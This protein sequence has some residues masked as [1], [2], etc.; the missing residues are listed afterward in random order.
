ME[1]NTM[2][3]GHRTKTWGMYDLWMV[4]ST[5]WFSKIVNWN[6][7][8][9]WAIAICTTFIS[10]ILGIGF[11]IDPGVPDI[12]GY[13]IFAVNAICSLPMLFM[14]IF[15]TRHD[16]EAIYKINSVEVAYN[17]MSKK[18]R[19][20]YKN[21]LHTLYKDPERDLANNLTKLFKHYELPVTDSKAE[22]VANLVT[23]ELDVLERAK[24]IAEES[25][26]NAQKVR[27][28]EST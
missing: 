26:A 6:E 2:L 19:K 15:G 28:Y 13:I 16:S 22:I 3:K 7:F 5:R 18:D 8:F 10:L 11:V 9:N 17:N 1:G 12:A 27:Q 24:Q 20:K 21:Y 4:P 23:S 14:V 25:M